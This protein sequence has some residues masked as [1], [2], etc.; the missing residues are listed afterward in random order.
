MER[1]VLAGCVRALRCRAYWR[2]VQ[3]LSH[4]CSP[5]VWV[6]FCLF[7]FVFIFNF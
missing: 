5:D 1:A 2:R 7:C 6:V 4:E 3:V